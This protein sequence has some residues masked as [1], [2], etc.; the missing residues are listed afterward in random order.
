MFMY[1]QTNCQ[2]Y[3]QNKLRAVMVHEGVHLIEY[4]L[5]INTMKKKNKIKSVKKSLT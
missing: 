4:L 5:I 2:R 1:M 3:C